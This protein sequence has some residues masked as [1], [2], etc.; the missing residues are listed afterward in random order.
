ESLVRYEEGV[1]LLRQCHGALNDAER[2]ILLLTSVDE[3]GTAIVEPF[4]DRT[5][6]LD[7]KRD[8][9]SRRR[10]RSAPVTVADC[11]EDTEEAD[12]ATLGAAERESGEIDRQKGLF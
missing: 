7:E 8:Q 4:D 5:L 2:K 12:E 6:S 9:R 3:S 10:S 11:A 1:R